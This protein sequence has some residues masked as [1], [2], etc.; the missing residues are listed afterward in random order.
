MVDVYG[1][2]GVHVYANVFYLLYMYC[3]VYSI[4][5]VSGTSNAINRHKRDEIVRFIL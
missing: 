2:Y 1:G 5:V 4:R 3:M